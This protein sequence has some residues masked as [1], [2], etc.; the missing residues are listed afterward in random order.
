MSTKNQTSKYSNLAELKLFKVLKMYQKGEKLTFE[1]E[2]H[3]E[4]KQVQTYFF[5]LTF[6]GMKFVLVLKKVEKIE[7]EKLPFFT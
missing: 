6:I 1:G 2:N 5:L 4:G 3:L 7:E